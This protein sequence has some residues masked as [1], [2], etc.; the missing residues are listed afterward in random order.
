VQ[1]F[2]CHKGYDLYPKSFGRI[3]WKNETFSDLYSEK[4]PWLLSGNRLKAGQ[5]MVASGERLC[6]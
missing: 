4:S 5:L 1:K 2:V 6:Q 3:L